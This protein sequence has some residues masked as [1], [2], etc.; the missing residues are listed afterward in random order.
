M[1]ACNTQSIFDPLTSLSTYISFQQ[2]SYN[3]QSQC[4]RRC[5]QFNRYVRVLIVTEDIGDLVP[6]DTKWLESCWC[7]IH[8]LDLSGS[9]SVQYAATT[10]PWSSGGTCGRRLPS[11]SPDWA[12][13]MD[14]FAVLFTGLG[15]S[16][17]R[18]LTIQHGLLSCF[19]FIFNFHFFCMLFCSYLRQS[20]VCQRKTFKNN[21]RI[22]YD[23]SP[24]MYSRKIMQMGKNSPHAF[25]YNSAEI[26]P[27]WMKSGRI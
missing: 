1:D 21:Q 17:G 7:N 22:D 11:L 5:I 23:Y 27:I 10:F 3:K 15:D 9:L 25:G 20:L 24:Q 16:L 14:S 6:A 18:C 2:I 19:T 26:E 4:T 8:T 12:D 13:T